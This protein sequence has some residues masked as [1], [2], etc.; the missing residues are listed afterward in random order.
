MN[1]TFAAGGLRRAGRGDGRNRI[2]GGSKKYV[3]SKEYNQLSRPANK[4]Y[5]KIND[6]RGST[7]TEPSNTT[8]SGGTEAEAM[9]DRCDMLPLPVLPIGR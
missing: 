2:I 6:T 1:Y 4:L 8:R 9:R 5:L 7:R 3:E